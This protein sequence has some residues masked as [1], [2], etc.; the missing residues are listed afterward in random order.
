MN[1]KLLI[2]CAT[3]H[4]QVGRGNRTRF[5]LLHDFEGGCFRILMSVS[6]TTNVKE[7]VLAE[8]VRLMHADCDNRFSPFNHSV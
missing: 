5:Y 6:Y 2:I 3:G 1:G 4:L 7:N 8:P